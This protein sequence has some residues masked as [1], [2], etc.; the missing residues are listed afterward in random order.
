MTADCQTGSNFCLTS[1]SASNPNLS[2]SLE[3][4]NPKS[5]LICQTGRRRK[6]VSRPGLPGCPEAI[7]DLIQDSAPP[8]STRTFI[9]L[10]RYYGHQHV[11][12]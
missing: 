7:S 8:V 3:I 5:S 2:D 9:P 6:P 10:H 11:S 1:P 4:P 12:C